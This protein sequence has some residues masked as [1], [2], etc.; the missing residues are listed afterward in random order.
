MS[1]RK[2][3]WAAVVL[4]FGVLFSSGAAIHKYRSATVSTAAVS[5]EISVHFSGWEL[6]TYN[7]PQLRW[8][9]DGLSIQ[10]SGV[11]AGVYFHRR[12]ARDESY[13]LKVKGSN[14]L[15]RASIR[16][17]KNGGEPTWLGAPDGEKILFLSSM[18][19]IEILIYADTAFEFRL[20]NLSL[21]RVPDVPRDE[22]L[23]AT[24]LL[25]RPALAGLLESGQTLPALEE[26]VTWTANTVAH[27]QDQNFSAINTE[28]LSQMSAAEGHAEI[29]SKNTGGAFCGAFALYFSKILNIFEIDAFTIDI[30]FTENSVTHVTTIVP[31]FQDGRYRF[32]LFDPTFS[33]TYRHKST[34][35]YLDIASVIDMS[36]AG[37]DSF[38]LVNSVPIARR[39]FF[40]FPIS[41]IIKDYVEAVY[42]QAQCFPGM[43]RER[44]VVICPTFPYNLDIYRTLWKPHLDAL[45]ISPS[46]DLIL[47][48][49]KGG[50]YNVTGFGTHGRS[51]DQAR[52]EL[53]AVLARGQ[54]PS[55]GPEGQS[56]PRHRL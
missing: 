14:A 1:R 56:Q 33:L 3:L 22:A 37:S 45:G 6:S 29:W 25:D 32:F 51:L 55:R 46:D 41:N 21:E 5:S 42:D 12:M 44:P 40:D 15:A 17:R 39:H 48:L 23:K 16:L 19:E 52:T 43:T 27:G 20:D 10:G 9:T 54:V 38:H 28:S 35:D 49:L 36:N 50:L 8:N 31:I 53:L 34:N 7:Q 18:D 13:R 24:I 47:S 11:P 2:A 26:L 30:G 4:A